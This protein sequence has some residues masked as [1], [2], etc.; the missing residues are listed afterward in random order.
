MPT[1]LAAKAV[2]AVANYRMKDIVP[3]APYAV[4]AKVLVTGLVHRNCFVNTL[5]H[6]NAIGIEKFDFQDPEQISD[7]EVRQLAELMI[8]AQNLVL[9][10]LNARPTEQQ[11]SGRRRSAKSSLVVA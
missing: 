5:G 10:R 8:A 11:G 7:P 1:L 4:G 9:E 2:P 3:N 6:R